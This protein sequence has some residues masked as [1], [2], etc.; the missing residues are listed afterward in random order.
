MTAR[1][2]A[3]FEAAARHAG[4]TVAEAVRHAC[5]VYMRVEARREETNT[6]ELAGG[7]TVRLEYRSALPAGI[8]ED[9]FV[10][11]FGP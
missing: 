9:A 2:H 4:L 1:E 10:A 7:G 8:T 5:A 6:P 11:Q 3:D